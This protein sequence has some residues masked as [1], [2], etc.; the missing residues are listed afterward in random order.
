MYT[1]M[2][3]MQF[4]TDMHTETGLQLQDAYKFIYSLNKTTYILQTYNLLAQTREINCQKHKRPS[5]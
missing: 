1:C 4:L 3:F 2:L 5:H